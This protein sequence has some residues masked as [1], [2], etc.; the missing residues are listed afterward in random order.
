MQGLLNPTLAGIVILLAGCLDS[1]PAATPTPA[2]GSEDTNGAVGGSPPAS[3]TPP[4]ASTVATQTVCFGGNFTRNVPY[5]AVVM[6]GTLFRPQNLTDQTRAIVLVHGFAST[7]AFT[8]DGGPAGFG[9]AN[10]TTLSRVLASAGYAVFTMD[11]LGMGNN[12][13]PDGRKLTIQSYVELTGDLVAQIKAGTYHT[14]TAA[15]PSDGPAPFK[16][17]S[18]VVGGHSFGALIAQNYFQTSDEADGLLSLDLVHALSETTVAAWSDCL[19]R[20]NQVDPAPGYWASACTREYCLQ[21]FFN[22]PGFDAASV[23][24]LCDPARQI[25]DSQGSLT[26]VHYHVATMSERLLRGGPVFLLYAECAG[27]FNTPPCDPKAREKET[28]SWENMC[29]S[30][31]VREHVLPGVAHFYMLYPAANT[32]ANR[33][34]LEWLAASGLAP[35]VV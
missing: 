2:D 26:D 12:P 5:V 20:A 7:G 24:L 14:S 15:C 1:S 27:S 18:V 31:T 8:F 3:G 16:A 17:A 33:V 34:V 29:P 22:V 23:E 25:P 21:I 32:E 9:V 13:Y 10:Q 30:C 11:R 19:A 6:T 28:Q 4:Q 35:T